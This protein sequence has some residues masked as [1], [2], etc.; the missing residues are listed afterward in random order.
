MG[1]YRGM[2][3]RLL[4]S[5]NRKFPGL[6]HALQKK[7]GQVSNNDDGYGTGDAV[8]LRSVVK[9]LEKEIEEDLAKFQKKVKPD[10]A[11]I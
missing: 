9:E 4:H 5:C 6:H 2:E 3:P 1:G 11:R 7:R 8:L 10:I